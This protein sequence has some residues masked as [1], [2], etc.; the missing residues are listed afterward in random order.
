MRRN[1]NH[2]HLA[3]LSP[4]ETRSLTA[5]LFAAAIEA[6][7]DPGGGTIRIRRSRNRVFHPAQIETVIQE[8]LAANNA[9]SAPH[10]EALRYGA[11]SR[12][13]P[14]RWPAPA[15]PSA[16]S[17]AFIDEKRQLRGFDRDRYVC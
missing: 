13:A 12:P 11:M 14:P 5:T 4:E 7:S 15:P 10:S 8:W 3:G 17:L 1:L 9:R 2:V 16:R 6:E